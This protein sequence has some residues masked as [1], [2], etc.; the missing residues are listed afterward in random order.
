[1]TLRLQSRNPAPGELHSIQ[2]ADLTGAC[3]PSQVG[4]N[5]WVSFV[6]SSFLAPGPPRPEAFAGASA[7][8][9]N[10]L[11]V[12]HQSRKPPGNTSPCSA[13][14]PWLLRRQIRAPPSPG[15]GFREPEMMW[16]KLCLRTSLWRF[17]LY[18]SG[19][20]QIRGCETIR[21]KQLLKIQVLLAR[22]A[23]FGK[24]ASCTPPP[25]VRRQ[26]GNYPMRGAG[27]RR[28]SSAKYS[29]RLSS[30][31]STKGHSRAR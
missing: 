23:R 21:E 2:P 1:M 9:N 16:E 26:Q 6:S 27:L 25:H 29:W 13:P 31:S 7:L 30:H 11:A 22:W 19:E 17:N 20:W 18:S 8:P 3:F 4:C 14:A 5:T 12:S 10:G 28:N 24:R 15:P